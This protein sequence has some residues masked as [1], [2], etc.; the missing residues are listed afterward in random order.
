MALGQN[1]ARAN[2]KFPA[3][4]KRFSGKKSFIVY[5]ILTLDFDLRL[6]YLLKLRGQIAL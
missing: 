4:V 3:K 5:L 2:V 1:G 6:Q